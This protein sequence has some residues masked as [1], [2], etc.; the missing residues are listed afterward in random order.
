M[1]PVNSL[2]SSFL[3]PARN[4]NQHPITALLPVPRKIVYQDTTP[5]GGPRKSR[6]VTYGSA[7]V[8]LRNLISIPRIFTVTLTFYGVHDIALVDRIE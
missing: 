3:N 8:K 1:I 2:G 6:L 4:Q 7:K 5:K